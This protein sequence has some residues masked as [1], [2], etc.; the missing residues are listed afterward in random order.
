[1][2]GIND[3]SSGNPELGQLE[4]RS[5]HAKCVSLIVTVARH[6]A[7]IVAVTCSNCSCQASVMSHAA[8]PTRKGT[9][10]TIGGH[11][12]IIQRCCVHI[13]AMLQ[14]SEF[15]M[16]ASRPH[17]SYRSRHQLAFAASAICIQELHQPHDQHILIVST[18]P[19]HQTHAP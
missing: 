13:N 11:W 17:N 8:A 15:G 3:C 7:D 6:C 4:K 19:M 5:L 16:H 14:T 1:M 12:K 2:I 10:F 18:I 9:M